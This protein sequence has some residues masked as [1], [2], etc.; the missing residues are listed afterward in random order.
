MLHFVERL[1][2]DLLI[3][4]L[5]DILYPHAG[6]VIV[7]SLQHPSE[8][9]TLKNLD[10]VMVTNKKELT[11]FVSSPLKYKKWNELSRFDSKSDNVSY[12]YLLLYMQLPV[13]LSVSVVSVL[14]QTTALVTLDGQETVAK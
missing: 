14:L 7:R 4:V 13:H 2:N 9:S 12:Y 6:M 8:L 11:A 3:C 10:V 1:H 5:G